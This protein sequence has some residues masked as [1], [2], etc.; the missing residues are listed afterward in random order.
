MSREPLELPEIVETV[1]QYL[2]Q[3]D[4]RNC[5]CVN[6]TWREIY[7]PLFWSDIQI[8][9]PSGTV[10]SLVL[11]KRVLLHRHYIQHLSLDYCNL[12]DYTVIFPNLKSLILKCNIM[13]KNDDDNEGDLIKMILLNKSVTRLWIHSTNME[14]NRQLW[15]AI[16]RLPQLKD[17]HLPIVRLT[18]SED[19]Q[20]FCKACGNLERLHIVNYCYFLN[21]KSYAHIY[22]HTDAETET[23]SPCELRFPKIKYLDLTGASGLGYRMIIDIYRH[24][25]EL[26][27]LIWPWCVDTLLEECFENKT[28]PNLKSLTL[29]QCDDYESLVSIIK[30]SAPLER[31]D[32]SSG[33]LRPTFYDSL[34]YHYGTLVELKLHCFKFPSLY[35]PPE[36]LSLTPN[37]KVLKCGRMKAEEVVESKPWVCLQLEVMCIGFMFDPTSESLQPQIFERISGLHRLRYLR[38]TE[39]G[40]PHIFTCRVGLDF[41]LRYGLW[42]L[43]TLKNL[44]TLNI[45]NTQQKMMQ[46][47]VE[48]IGKNLTRLAV[49][50]GSMNNTGHISGALCLLL[51]KFNIRNSIG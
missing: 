39:C 45:Q 40:K 9:T 34:E 8:V 3:D 5:M 16:A 10:K 46:E 32:I 37:L 4:K 19:A 29:S 1:A 7:L 33:N 48:W 50:Q 12:R 28:W 14:S 47:D 31:L 51:R 43:S 41:R 35:T 23:E 11:P 20:L 38:I 22:T 21:I 18:T 2:S 42:K 44:Q 27:E 24:S 17:L 49:I 30:D 13:M 6:K 25:P 26:R 36:V 15:M